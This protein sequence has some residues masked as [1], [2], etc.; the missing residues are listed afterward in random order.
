[1]NKC[2]SIQLHH[3]TLCKLIKNTLPF[4]SSIISLKRNAFLVT[5]TFNTRVHTQD[6]QTIWYFPL[7]TIHN[8]DF[9]ANFFFLFFSSFKYHN[10]RALFGITFRHAQSS[11]SKDKFIFQLRNKNWKRRY[12]LLLKL[13]VFAVNFL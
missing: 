6:T 2:L 4:C 11:L 7:E 12:L 13:V 9:G 10:E 5:D 3:I 1:M 8:N